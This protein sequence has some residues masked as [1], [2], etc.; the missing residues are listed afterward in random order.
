MSRP[1]VARFSYWQ[2]N[3]LASLRRGKVFRELG[4]ITGTIFGRLLCLAILAARRLMLKN[5]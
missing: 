3:M 2:L 4:V 5:P 1:M